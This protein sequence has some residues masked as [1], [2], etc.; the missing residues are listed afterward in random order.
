MKTVTANLLLHEKLEYVCQGVTLDER[1]SRARHVQ[2]VDPSFVAFMRM[3]GLQ[4]N[5][6]WGI[7]EGMPDTYKPATDIPEGYSYTTA[8]QELRR[9]QNFHR[10]GTMQAV[11]KH[12]RETVWIQLL[13]GL[14]WKE[15]QVLI[16]I[17]DQV[18]FA[19]YPQLRETLIALGMPVDVAEPPPSKPKSSRKKKGDE[20]EADAST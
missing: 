18:L 20:A 5:K 3:A 4:A 15:A 11:P 14:H 2:T 10:D 12:R 19:Q 6:I 8:R 9:L 13:E 17:K 1:M 7:P 16:A